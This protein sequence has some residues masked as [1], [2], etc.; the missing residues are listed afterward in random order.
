MR[1]EAAQNGTHFLITGGDGKVATLTQIPGE[2]N[3]IAGR[4]EFIVNKSGNLTHQ[5]F[6]AGGT[7][8]GIPNKP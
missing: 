7:I 3:G 4:F 8:N 1:E 6:V 2:Y 5:R